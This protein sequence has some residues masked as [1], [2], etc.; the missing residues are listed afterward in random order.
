MLE[1]IH[2]VVK[3]FSA[4]LVEDEGCVAE[5]AL[6]DKIVLAVGLR[7]DVKNLAGRLAEGFGRR[8]IVSIRLSDRLALDAFGAGRIDGVPENLSSEFG[9]DD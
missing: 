6:G 9:S 7:D 2:D 3:V 1:R 8:E 4:M 5:N